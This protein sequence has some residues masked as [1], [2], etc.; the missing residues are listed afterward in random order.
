MSEIA[1]N[2]F[3]I[4]KDYI[5]RYWVIKHYFPKDIANIILEDEKRYRDIVLLTMKSELMDMYLFRYCLLRKI[6]PKEITN[7]ILFP[8]MFYIIYLSI[9]FTATSIL[10]KIASKRKNIGYSNNSQK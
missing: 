8:D 2:I 1:F 9:M 7:M 6:F 5:F 3:L 4:P 10:L